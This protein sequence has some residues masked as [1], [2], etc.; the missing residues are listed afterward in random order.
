MSQT[1]PPIFRKS[2][3]MYL[4]LSV[5][6]AF[7][8]LL[9]FPLSQHFL[10]FQY[11]FERYLH[12]MSLMSGGRR[13][14]QVTTAA[15]LILLGTQCALAQSSTTTTTTM[16]PSSSPAA[17]PNVNTT[18]W[19]ADDTNQPEENKSW[20]AQHGRFAFVIVLG[21]LVLA[22]L[23]WYIVWSVR[24][25]RRRLERENQ[26][27]LQVLQQIKQSNEASATAAAP[28]RY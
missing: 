26:N 28:Q 10:L 24:G 20:L 15:G 17:P 1:V 6:Y 23:I 14:T 22:L 9:F 12:C 5:L 8:F 2:H 18:G 19:N 4:S 7:F 11:S 16:L 27:Q 21:I 3:F 13:T 25:M